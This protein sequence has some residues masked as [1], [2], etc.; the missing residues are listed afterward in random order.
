MASVLFI[1]ETKIKNF[2]TVNQNVDNE[3]LMSNIL[4]AQDLGLQNL[5]G[6]KGYNYYINLIKSVQLSGGTMSTPDR[7]LLEDYIGP[8]LLHR[9]YFE[10]LPVLYMR[11]VNKALTVGDTEQ[12]KSVGIKEMQYFREIEQSRYEFYSQR[13]M[14]Y[15]RNNPND[16]PWYWSYSSTDGMPVSKETYFAGIQFEPGLRYPP[17]RRSWARNLPRYHGWEYDCG[18]CNN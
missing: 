13:L 3:L 16:Y 1:S 18:D 2:T 8:Y 14:D 12:G 5:L 11:T 7:T 9:A 15:I 4:I 6:T 17:Q 10:S